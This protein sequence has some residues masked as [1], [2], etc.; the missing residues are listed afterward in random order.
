MKNL[1]GK[2]HLSLVTLAVAM[3]TVCTPVAKANA[4]YDYTGT[5]FTTF[6]VISGGPINPYSSTDFAQFGFT[7]AAPLGANFSGTVTPLLWA[8]GDGVVS[9]EGPGGN[10]GALTSA[11]ITTNGA[12]QIT[13]W[14]FA[15]T[16]LSNANV[17]GMFGVSSGG[18][19]GVALPLEGGIYQASTTVAG[20]W[21]GPQQG[22]STP[23]PTPGVLIALSLA[24]LL[25][26]IARDL[27]RTTN[28]IVN[29]THN[30]QS[31]L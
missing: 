22:L 26:F 27:F 25:L 16:S 24:G 5:E 3:A 11:F 30:F 19:F 4:S 21:A 28:S 6:Q 17:P 15:G 8:Y 7:V 23:E 9:L 2:K 20:T 14:H 13:A 10:V 18:D 31:Q 29:F 12:G 1:I